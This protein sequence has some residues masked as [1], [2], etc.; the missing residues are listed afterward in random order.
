MFTIV[1]WWTATLLLVAWLR[2]RT[3]WPL[4]L[5][6]PCAWVVTEWAWSF[7]SVGDLAFGLSGYTMFVYPRL[8][9]FAEVTGV[10]GVSFLIQ[11]V[12]GSCAEASLAWAEQGPGG[13]RRAAVAAPAGCAAIALAAALVHGTLCLSGARPEAGPRLAM[14]QPAIK[15]GLSEERVRYVHVKQLALAHREV[16]PGEADL[17]VFPENAVLK[18]IEGSSYLT[19]FQELIRRVGAPVLAGV[20]TRP[21]EDRRRRQRGETER[22]IAVGGR[23]F[24]RTHNTAAI[25]TA[26]GVV[27]RY[28]KVH[29][30]PFTE[31]MPGE[32]FFDAIGLLEG[33]RAFAVQVLGYLGTGVP[34]KGVRLLRIPASDAP[35]FWTPICF[36]QADARLSREARRRG[37][38]SFI[39]LTSEGDLGPQIYWNTVAVS[40][41][42]AVE[43]RV[44]IAR[45]GN[46]G[47][48]GVIDPWGRQTHHLRSESGALYLE[49]GV[50]KASVPLGP[51][52]L[53]LYARLGDWPAGASSLVVLAA[54]AAA[55]RRG[56]R[57]GAHTPAPR[58]PS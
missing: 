23:I 42:R 18:P 54:I 43:L 20:I 50:L 45:C 38:R 2:R 53:T 6:W 22:G 7:H 8:I 5:L 11:V 4:G 10:L 27:Q 32:P 15:H 52:G 41:L 31:R 35:P 58:A 28:D 9:Q 30:L 16:R 34:G 37:A 56:R 55:L 29:L 26:E 44:G 47:I 24:L 39:N 21:E 1:P 17:L 49:P 25:I 12:A 3:G 14:V 46:M 51:R 36:E 57:A 13:L 48:T 40:V 33:Y 19:Q